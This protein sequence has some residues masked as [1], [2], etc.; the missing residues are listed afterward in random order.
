M[1]NHDE[2]SAQSATA[3]ELGLRLRDR[4]QCA[5]IQC[6]STAGEAAAAARLQLIVPLIAVHA[7]S[8]GRVAFVMQCVPSLP[9]RP[10]Q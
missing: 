4:P 3:E 8:G 7:I 2:D 5:R 9:L 10:E 6:G 1:A